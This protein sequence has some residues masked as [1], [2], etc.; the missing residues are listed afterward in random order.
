MELDPETIDRYRRKVRY[1][2]CYHLGSFCQDVEDVV[3]ETVTRFLGAIQ[4]GKVRNPESLGAFLSGICNNVI[5]EYRRRL[6]KEP[7]SDSDSNPPE[8]MV[9]PEAELLDLREAIDAALAQL[10]KRDRDILRAFFL[11]EKSKD[12]ICDSM[13]LSDVQF[14]VALFRAKDRFR[15]IYH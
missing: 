10:P 14:R 7:L 8:A 1:K 9:P 11:Q 15:K 6:W 5:L 3:Q 13:G 12:E 2:V 4:D